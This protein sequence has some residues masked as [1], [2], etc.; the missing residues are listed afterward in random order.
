[1][2]RRVL[3]ALAAG[4]LMPPLAACDGPGGVELGHNWEGSKVFVLTEVSGL[5]TI[6]GIDPARHTAEPLAAV[7]TQSDDDDTASPQITKTTNGR[8][9]VTVPRKNGRPSRLYEVNTKDQVLDALGTT[10]G[11]RVLIPAGG[12]LAAVGDKAT[13][14]T[15]KATALVY[16]PATWQVK[17][18]VTLPVNPG[19]AAGGTP[20]LCVGDNSDKGFTLAVVSPKNGT[21]KAL[22]QVPKTEAQALDCSTSR[23]LLA[24]GPT[25]TSTS[26]GTATLHL[27]KQG[28]IDVL[29]TSAGRID[30][31]TADSTSITA[32]V[33]LP[34]HVELVEVDRSTGK[35]RHRTRLDGMAATDGMRKTG[36]HWVLTSGDSAVTVDLGHGKATAFTLPG[37]LL[38]AG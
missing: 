11:G 38:N 16:D 27:A 20:G 2:M 7:P 19:L 36:K 30:R 4:A 8:W 1:M 23:P 10:E 15:G 25:T 29:T 21:V 9:I 24:G 31:V 34:G 33:S 14:S 13:S 5:T 32:A 26:T 28:E 18:D 6:T 35:E 37:Q 22:P 12:Y 17:R 3:P